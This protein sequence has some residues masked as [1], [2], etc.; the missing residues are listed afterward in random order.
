VRY[1]TEQKIPDQAAIQTA[2]Q[3]AVSYLNELN[4][5]PAAPLQKRTLSW[6]KLTLA[7]PLPDLTAATLAAYDANPGAF[8]LPTAAQRAPY[9]LQFVFTRPTGVSQVLDSEAVPALVLAPFE[10]LSL[11]KV[12]TE[13]KPKG[14][15]A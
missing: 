2:L 9:T 4:A 13:V 12:S 7:T 5:A 1:T 14:A 3:T 8:T 11:A 6:G 10:R 15:S